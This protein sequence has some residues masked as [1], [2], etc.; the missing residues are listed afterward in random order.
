MTPEL[1]TQVEPENASGPQAPVLY[2]RIGLKRLILKA[3]TL[4]VK[5]LVECIHGYRFFEHQAGQGIQLRKGVAE[6]PWST[7]GKGHKEENGTTECS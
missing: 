2:I 5:S 7:E 4:S 6:G 3:L 1:V